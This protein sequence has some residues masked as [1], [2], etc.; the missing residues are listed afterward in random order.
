MSQITK[1]IRLVVESKFSRI[2]SPLEASELRD[3]D[4]VRV[5]PPG[6]S[7]P[8]HLPG[9]AGP[10]S[11]TMRKPTY[12]NKI[13]TVADFGGTTERGAVR[14]GRLGFGASYEGRFVDGRQEVTIPIDFV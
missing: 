14:P 11:E 10:R 7:S 6:E 4:G 9:K 8:N 12:R 1:I 13:P 5:R 2:D 3:R